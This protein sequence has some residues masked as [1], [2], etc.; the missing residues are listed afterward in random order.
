MLPQQRS[1]QAVLYDGDEPLD[2]VGESHYQ[3]ELWGIVGG[4]RR[5]PV[6]EDVIAL[7]L[8]EPNNP[9]DENAIGVWVD[10]KLVGYLSRQDAA[11]YREGLLRLLA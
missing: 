7:L 1:V 8:P 3:E 11:L 4:R 9:V 5:D 6:R 2:V 10:L